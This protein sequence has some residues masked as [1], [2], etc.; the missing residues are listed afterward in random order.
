MIVCVLLLCPFFSHASSSQVSKHALLAEERGDYGSFKQVG[1]F[2]VKRNAERLVEKLKKLG[3]KA[4]FSEGVTKDDK[5]IY[6]VF[7]KEDQTLNRE[8]A[9]SR[10]KPAQ[11]YKMVASER[12]KAPAKPSYESDVLTQRS[13]D[14]NVVYSASYRV[15]R[16]RSQAE[17]Y[18][19]AAR[20][21][22]FNT[23]IQEDISDLSNIRYTVLTMKQETS[24]ASDYVLF[25]DERPDSDIIR[26]AEQRKGEAAASRLRAKEKIAGG[27]I[28]ASRMSRGASVPPASEG[29]RKGMTSETVSR[30]AAAKRSSQTHVTS[31]ASSSNVTGSSMQPKGQQAGAVISGNIEATGKDPTQAAL[32]TGGSQPDES[33]PAETPFPANI[34]VKNDGLGA[35]DVYG[36][37]GGY[38]HPFVNFRSYFTDNVYHSRED[39]ESDFVFVI[40]PGIWL[41]VPGVRQK[42]VSIDSSTITPGGFLLSRYNPQSFRRYQ[43]YFFYGTD[44]EVFTKNSSENFI[45]HKIEGMFE[46]NLKSG[47]TLELV[48]RYQFSHDARGTGT[49]DRLDKYES[50]LFSA[51]LMYDT[52][53]RL[54]FRGDYSHY[55]VDYSSSRNSFRDRQDNAF[56]LYAFYRLSPKT[57]LLG[58]YRYIDVDYRKDTLSNS[59]EHH[60][61]GGVYWDITTKS[62]GQVKAGYGVKEFS[63]SSVDTAHNFIFESQIDYR[64]T[65]KTS[66][67]LKGYRK[68]QESNIDDADYI[69]STGGSLQYIQR[70]TRKISASARVGYW[71]EQYKDGDVTLGDTTKKRED[72]IFEV[73]LAFR[74]DLKEW[75]KCD[76]GYLYTNRDSTFSEHDYSNNTFFI[77]LSGG[78]SYSLAP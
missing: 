78:L 50:N 6:R 61:L 52:R 56:S 25:D 36:Q 40:S 63:R 71:N 39:K 46:Y 3:E 62:R 43:T 47:F 11:S 1:A 73:G 21:Q 26:R 7:V 32:I 12:S 28:A 10:K 9:N 69:L 66:I 54:L 5:T 59:R 72:D 45:N 30:I 74:Y 20:R 68:T 27:A 48:D 15:F 49:S 75:L 37:E 44:I 65:P 70:M 16:K 18:A 22:G 57:K 29:V 4:Y 41:T 67:V 55:Y 38:I 51:I 13:A 64:F 42:L 58:Q 33:S 77:G 53:K 35:K 24:P 76:V 8:S 31:G 19:K 23:V 14:H 17:A 2:A 34:T 60:Y